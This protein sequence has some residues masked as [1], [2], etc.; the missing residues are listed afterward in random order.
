MFARCRT[1]FKVPSW[2]DG[3]SSKDHGMSIKITG[4]LRIPHRMI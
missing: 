1:L 4:E 2:I 3:A